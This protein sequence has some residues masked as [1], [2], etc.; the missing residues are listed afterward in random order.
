[1]ARPDRRDAG[2]VARGTIFVLGSAWVQIDPQQAALHLLQIPILYGEQFGLAARALAQAADQ[3]LKLKRTD[4]ARIVLQE[5]MDRH[6]GTAEAD[7]A[8]EKLAAIA[9]TQNAKQP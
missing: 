9:A 5:L 2:G 4:E 7:F 1:M 8:A 6:G 3:L